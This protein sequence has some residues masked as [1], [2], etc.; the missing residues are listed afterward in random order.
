MALSIQQ[1]TLAETR[2]SNEKKSVGTAYILWFLLGSF[3]A[4]RFYLGSTGV[5]I[6]QLILIWLGALLSAV[7]IG[8]PMIVVGVIWVFIDAF[9]IPGMV[10]RDAEA[11]R[12]RIMQEVAMHTSA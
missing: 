1:M 3:A 7:V 2:L 9:L 4:H 5:A 8:I 12:S 11:K 10:A 6:T